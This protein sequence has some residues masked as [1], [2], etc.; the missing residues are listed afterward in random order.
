MMRLD[1]ELATFDAL[2]RERHHEPA[3]LEQFYALGMLLIASRPGRFPANILPL[4]AQN[5]SANLSPTICSL[6]AQT[7][8][9]RSPSSA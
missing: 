6:L 3:C 5:Y 2:H 4:F 9:A 1:S 8:L 7:A